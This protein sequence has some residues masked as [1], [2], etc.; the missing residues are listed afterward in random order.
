MFLN[1]IHFYGEELFALRPTPKLENHPL[2]VVGD[3]LF[4]II[5]AIL[6][7]AGLLSIPRMRYA[8]MKGHILSR[9]Q[10]IYVNVINKI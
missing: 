5:A 3:C 1:R 9:I 2:S 6:H 7:I 8:V 10:A 4:N